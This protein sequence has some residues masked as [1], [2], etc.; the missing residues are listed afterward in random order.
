[1][2]YNLNG[3]DDLEV[4]QMQSD[5]SYNPSIYRGLLMFSRFTAFLVAF[6]CELGVV[7][8]MWV[9]SSRSYGTFILIVVP[10]Y[11][12]LPL[13]LGFTL[14]RRLSKLIEKDEI[15]EPVAAPIKSGIWGLLMVVYIGLGLMSNLAFDR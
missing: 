6:A 14:D 12:A 8:E 9:S 1:M 13:A 7:D 5:A 2:T 15:R 4:L 10:I 3:N 11:L